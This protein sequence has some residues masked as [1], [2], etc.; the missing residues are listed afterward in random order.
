[1]LI[2]FMIVS[3]VIELLRDL[4]MDVPSLCFIMLV[5]ISCNCRVCLGFT[6]MSFVLVPLCGLELRYTFRHVINMSGSTLV[7]IIE[8]L[9]D[10][11]LLNHTVEC[12]I[13]CRNNVCDLQDY[14]NVNG[15]SFG[16]TICKRALGD[17]A[18]SLFVRIVIDRCVHCNR[19]VKIFVERFMT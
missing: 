10:V 2:T 13:C 12:S 1:M 14:V 9:F 18:N 6:S 15:N 19:C 5:A 4:Y 8:V 17:I 16:M 11:L 3:I 7:C